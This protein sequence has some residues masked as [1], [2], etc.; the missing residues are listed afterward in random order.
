MGVVKNIVH[1][2]FMKKL[3]W[4]GHMQKMPDDKVSLD[5]SGLGPSSRKRRGRPAKS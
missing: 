4:Y 1:E 5:G 2:I 3:V